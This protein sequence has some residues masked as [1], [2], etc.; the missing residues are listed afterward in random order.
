MVDIQYYVSSGI[1]H[2]E[3]QFLKVILHLYYYTIL[4]IFSVLNN[5]SL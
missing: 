5:M 3:S 4:G 2:S 1:Q